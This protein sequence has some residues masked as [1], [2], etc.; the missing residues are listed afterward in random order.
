MVC[1]GLS[2]KHLCG[3]VFWETLSL[4][5]HSEIP[6]SH[7]QSSQ[8]RETSGVT[9]QRAES[10]AGL[11]GNHRAGWEV[12]HMLEPWGLDGRHP[13]QSKIN[14]CWEEAS[15]SWKGKPCLIPWVPQTQ[16]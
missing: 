12:E 16:G 9:E 5:N 10:K 8:T 14:I 4:F 11:Q 6:T 1:P 7:L 2:E 3:S 13:V 15:L